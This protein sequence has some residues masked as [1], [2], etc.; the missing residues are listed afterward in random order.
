MAL[1][2]QGQ[3]LDGPRRLAGHA[4]IAAGTVDGP[5]TQADAGDAVVLE[6]DA[7]IAFIAAFE[8]AVVRGRCQQ[9]IIGDRRLIL[10]RRPE[11]RGG[12]GI[13]EPLYLPFRLAHRLEDGQCSQHVHLGTQQRVGSADRYLEAG[14]MDDVGNVVFGQCMAKARKVGDIALDEARLLHL[15]RRQDQVEPMR[16]FL[17]IINEDL[18]ATVEQVANDPGAD[19]A[20]TAGEKDTHEKLQ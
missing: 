15:L 7:G 13:N 4:E 1:A 20:V 9:H 11:D 12:T 2:A 5:G 17:E 10:F 8:N 6:I 18:V 19:T 16:V 14:E 3:G